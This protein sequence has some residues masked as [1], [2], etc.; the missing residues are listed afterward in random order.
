VVPAAPAGAAAG[1]GPAEGPPQV[2]EASSAGLSEPV[3][4]T[5][6]ARALGSAPRLL[7]SRSVKSMT[8]FSPSTIIVPRVPITHSP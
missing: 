3:V 6:T 1:V 5:P 8:D 7:G 4:L 2:E